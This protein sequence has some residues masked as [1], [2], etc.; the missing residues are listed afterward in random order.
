MRATYSLE[1]NSTVKVWGGGVKEKGFSGFLF[2]IQYRCI[3]QEEENLQP[4]PTVHLREMPAGD[5]GK[6][7]RPAYLTTHTKEY[8]SNSLSTQQIQPSR[9]KGSRERNGN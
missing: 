6:K 9:T 4:P 2:S 8:N 1:E 3:L 5:G 7:A